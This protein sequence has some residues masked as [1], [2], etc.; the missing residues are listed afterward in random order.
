MVAVYVPDGVPK[1][2]VLDD[3]ALP[4]QPVMAMKAKMITG[5]LRTGRRRLALIRRKEAIK[6]S[7]HSSLGHPGK[8]ADDTPAAVPGAVVVTVTV[9]GVAAPR[10]RLTDAGTLQLGAGVTTGFMAQIRDTVPLN[11]P[12]GVKV[13]LKVAVLPALMVDELPDAI[14]MVKSGRA[15][16]VELISTNTVGAL[17]DVSVSMI[18]S[19]LPS[20]FMSAACTV[21]FRE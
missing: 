20:P 6:T 2:P 10:V 4:P 5:N 16:T 18:K 3:E 17:F 7:V 21:A 14:P 11:D 8:S 1:V 9:T 19:G 15:E 12:A 13:K